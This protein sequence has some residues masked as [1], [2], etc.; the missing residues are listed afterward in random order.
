MFRQLNNAT[1][2]TI[3]LASLGAPALLVWIAGYYAW[4]AWRSYNVLTMTVQANVLADDIVTAAG[5]QA[6][7][8]GVTASLLSARGPADAAALQRIA[9]LRG[10]SD[11]AW[12]EALAVADK[13]EA[14]G[15]V[16]QGELVARKQAE[17]S[18]RKLEAVRARVDA[19]LAKSERDIAVGEWIP[20]MTGF[21]NTAARM[22]I[23]VFGGDAFPPHITYPNLTTKHSV[24]LASEFAG[25]ERATFAAIIN[26]NAPAA[27][28]ALQ[29]LGAYRQIVESNLASVR[30]VRDVPGT[31]PSVIAAIDAMDKDF[32]GDFNAVRQK[33]YAE[34]EGKATAST[35]HVY[36]MTAKEWIERSTQAIDTILKVSESY[37]AVGN[38][39]ARRDADI[40]FGQMLGY[41]GLFVAMIVTSI[42]TV[43]LL[44]GKLRHLDR[45]RK[46]MAQFATGEG[47]LTFRLEAVTRDEIGET[48][49]AFNSFAEKLQQIIG[50]TRSVVQQLTAA[51]DKLAAASE[52]VTS[53]SKAQSDLS[54]STAAA[55]EEIT[56]SIGQVAA[57]A[58]DARRF[59]RSRQA[60]GGG[61]AGRARSGGRNACAG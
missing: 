54:L 41:I 43:S 24:W 40:R 7:E 61:R 23:A 9:A 38:A 49:A 45:L 3:V 26:S 46:S 13:L 50:E 59:A 60:G 4:D 18:Y 17:E 15:Y 14:Q 57:R 27:P 19:S 5:L 31:D 11:A 20:A 56:A 37:S 36:S 39:E 51:A 47:D 44:L 42:V 22:R 34:A 8:R 58:R 28:D 48:S 25:L 29:R 21:I 30:F 12:K 33:L 53:G 16:Y 35:D 1:F 32:L 6:L 2:R 55:V 10:K 52:C